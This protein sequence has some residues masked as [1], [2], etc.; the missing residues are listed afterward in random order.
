MQVVDASNF[1]PHI[2]VLQ[3]FSLRIMC[4]SKEGGNY[5]MGNIV[6]PPYQ[7]LLWW[8]DVGVRERRT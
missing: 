7:L 2:Q 5:V 8:P 4:G 6:C 3:N 1:V